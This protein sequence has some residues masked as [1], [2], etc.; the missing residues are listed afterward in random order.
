MIWFKYHKVD[1]MTLLK[2]IPSDENCQCFIRKNNS[3]NIID[4]C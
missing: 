2:Q 1:T 3:D 4:I